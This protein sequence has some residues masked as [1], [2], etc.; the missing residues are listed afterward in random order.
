MQR[1]ELD[2]QCADVGIWEA[3]SSIGDDISSFQWQIYVADDGTFS[4]N[5]SSSELLTK[6]VDN[7]HSLQDAQRWCSEIDQ[8]H[9][10]NYLLI[11]TGKGVTVEVCADV[12][13]SKTFF[14]QH[15]MDAHRNPAGGCTTGHGF[16]ISWQN[17]PLAVDGERK[18]PNGAFVEDIIQAALDRLEFYQS[19]RFAH[20]DNDHAMLYLMN[21][22]EML[23]HRTK[24]RQKRGVE[25]THQP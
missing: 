20:I 3:A 2:W 21:A 15:W 6:K 18:A 9:A 8:M 7:F 10:K 23:E 12:A 5:D 16:T 14:S 24:E 13:S 19:S 25:G 1:T 22:L 4:V 17:G 11:D